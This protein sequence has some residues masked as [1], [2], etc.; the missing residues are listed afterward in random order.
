MRVTAG[1]AWPPAIAS[2][3]S[4]ACRQRPLRVRVTA[5]TARRGARREDHGPNRRTP[6][7]RARTSTSSRWRRRRWRR[8][9]SRATSSSCGRT[10]TGSGCRSRWPTG[11]SRRAPSRPSSC[12][13]APRRRKL[14][15]LKAGDTIPTYAGPLG[16]ATPRSA[17]SARSS[18]S[19]AATASAASTRS[20]ARSR[21]AGNNVV[22]APR[23][24]QLLP[25]LLA[26]DVPRPVSGRSSCSPATAPR[27]TRG[28]S[29]GSPEILTLEGI[30]PDRIIV[31]GCTFLMMADVRRD[32][33]RSGSGRS[34]T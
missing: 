19:A 14:A 28:T 27:A 21:A 20:P 16:Q 5:Q 24:A 15:R 11:T 13:S 17:T 2:S 4:R 18:A 7:D 30:R 8:R 31:N 32:R 6:H 33:G 29:R 22:T 23:G 9:C 3:R 12:R 25:P 1:A 10:T 26:G 34:S